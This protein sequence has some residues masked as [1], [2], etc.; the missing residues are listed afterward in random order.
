MS[1]KFISRFVVILVLVM[2]LAALSIQFF[3]DPHYTVVFWILA[4]PVILGAPILG[5]VI[6][7]SNEELDL[8]QLN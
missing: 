2:I 5:S 3:F 4:V 6:L 7:A 8:H 1:M